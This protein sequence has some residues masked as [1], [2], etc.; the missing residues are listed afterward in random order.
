MYKQDYKGE[1]IT[2]F[3]SEEKLGEPVMTKFIPVMENNNIIIGFITYSESVK[4]RLI[5]EKSSESLS[6]SLKQSEVGVAE[7][8]DGVSNLATLLNSINI[9]SLTL[10]EHVSSSK[11]M[12]SAINANASKSN[13]LALNAAIEAARA[14]ETGRGFAVVAKEMGSLANSSGETSK[15]VEITLSKM[16]ASLD[17]ITKRI[18]NANNVANFQA[19]AV[20]EI[21]AMLENVTDTSADLVRLITVNK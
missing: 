21:T 8:A 11:G 18:E 12:I 1:S 4:E 6:E 5:A 19:A 2:T 10:K 3:F 20:E 14:G 17:E 13:M 9:Q 7:I 15:N 16:Y